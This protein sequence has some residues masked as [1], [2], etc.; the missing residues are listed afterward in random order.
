MK[1]STYQSRIYLYALVLIIP[2]VFRLSLV[3]IA[4][5]K[6]SPPSQ[7]MPDVLILI[8]ASNP[9]ITSVS[10]IYPKLIPK[11][12]AEANLS[13]MLRETG[14]NASNLNISDGSAANSGEL[15]MTSI[16]FR[17]SFTLDMESG[18]LPIE[19]IIKA[20]RNVKQMEI[21]YILPQTFYFHGVG[22]FQNRY[23][24]IKLI[25][26][27]NAYRYAVHIKDPSF[28]TLGLP[29]PQVQSTAPKAVDRTQLTIKILIV[30]LALMAA[31]I[32]FMVSVRVTQ[33]RRRAG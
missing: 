12:V 23:V 19:P 15:P 27:N 28:T 2:I 33:S 18:Y 17:T 24:Q 10:I 31:A 25:S 14:W 4:A 21:Q 22:D 9:Q 8:V 29:K 1:S 7:Q 6:A 30:A 5:P 32:V 26:G 3:A 20:F 13:T 16:D 11:N